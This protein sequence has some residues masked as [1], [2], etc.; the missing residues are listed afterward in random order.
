[1]PDVT[2][3]DSSLVQEQVAR[4]IASPQLRDAPRLQSL[5]RFVI[6]LALAG[7]AEEIKES[8]IAR[9]VFSRADTTGDSIVRSAAGRLRTRLDEY[10]G[11]E[12][13]DD[14]VRI[15]IPRGSY[16]P[17]IHHHGPAA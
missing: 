17:V 2:A 8:T 5:L 3:A 15:S 12:G 4:L 9:E 13:V 10:Y 11:R 6:S 14:P 7:K 16:V 1:M